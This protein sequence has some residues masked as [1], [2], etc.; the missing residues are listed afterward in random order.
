MPI[1][2]LIELPFHGLTDRDF[3]KA[4]GQWVHNTSD[5]LTN[6]K[7]LYGDILEDPDKV[8]N[9]DEN[10]FDIESKY[11]S[12]KQMGSHFQ[13]SKQKAISILHCNTRSLAK[14]LTLLNDILLTINETPSIIAISETKLN[15]N[16][17]TNISIQGYIYLGTNSKTAA[18]GVGFYVREHLNY[19]IR[20]DLEL[21]IDGVESCWIE[22]KRERQKSIVV[23]CV[24]RHPTNDLNQFKT[25][26]EQKLTEVNNQGHEV[27]IVGDIN[28]NFLNYC[29]NNHTSEYLDMLLNLGFMPVITKSTRI[30]D[31]TSTLI[32]HIYTNTPQKVL[33]SGICLAD[34]SDHLPIFCTIGSKLPNVKELKFYRDFSNFKKESF[35][36][37]LNNIDFRSLI[38]FDVN[39][40]MENIVGAL[41]SVCDIH[42]PVKKVS[43]AKI[44]QQK[45]PWITNS[46][47][48]S[49]K[50]KQ[51]LFRTHFLSGK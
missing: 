28:I 8:S 13:S 23:G 5:L 20:F 22:L 48:N 35:L 3:H 18:G 7:D 41:K 1:N 15:E 17:Q 12:V 29:T 2:T 11:Y 42:A 9:L 14:N 10:G 44:K 31:H 34:I 40:S 19:T 47:L 6:M 24:Y 49:I 38:N 37:D 30:T 26:M 46:I 36:N 25:T 51:K 4:T 45:K 50:N 21:N 43:N 39:N 16:T 32:D 33:K 27:V